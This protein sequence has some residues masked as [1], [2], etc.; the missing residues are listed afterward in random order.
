MTEAWFSSESARLFSYLSGTPMGLEAALLAAGAFADADGQPGHVPRTL[1]S[2]C[3]VGLLFVV[4]R[5]A[6]A[7]AY[8]EAEL[9]RTVA[10]DL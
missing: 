9:R 6:V 7:R 5:S 1:C 3:V 8:D 2:G 4:M 10:A